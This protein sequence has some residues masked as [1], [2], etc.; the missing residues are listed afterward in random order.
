MNF[1][2]K[3]RNGITQQIKP[4]FIN[5]MTY[6]SQIDILDLKYYGPENI[7]G[8]RYVPAVIDNFSKFGTNNSCKKLKW[9]NSRKFF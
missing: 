7:R 1:T 4:M 3:D 2:L 9:S 6:G 8:Y 5:L